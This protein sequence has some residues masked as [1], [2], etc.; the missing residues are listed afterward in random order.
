MRYSLPERQ[1][2]LI[3]SE[4]PIR[5]QKSG[6][7]RIINF[8]QFLFKKYAQSGL[9]KKS[10]KIVT[11]SSL[12]KRMKGVFKT[13]YS[14]GVFEAFLPRLLLRKRRDETDGKKTYY[15]D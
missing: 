4:F 1:Y 5:L 6:Y 15:K 7:V 9:T 8:L 2:F 3:N 11:I 12:M 13:K 14:Y 10:D